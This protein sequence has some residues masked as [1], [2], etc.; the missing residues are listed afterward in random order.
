MSAQVF[1]VAATEALSL[2]Q[3]DRI[4]DSLL[5]RLRA[6]SEQDHAL[7]DRLASEESVTSNTFV[8]GAEGALSAESDDEVLALLHHEQGELK[9]VV[10]ALAR[11][12]EGSYG[13]C[14][15]CGEPIG[16]RRLQVLPEAALCVGCQSMAE[17]RAEVH[18]QAG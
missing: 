4:R 5:E 2:P 15:D 11:L 10:Q 6:L 16:W 8:A 7:R 14:S 9:A 3:L 13:A 12:D 1:S 17:H 18:R